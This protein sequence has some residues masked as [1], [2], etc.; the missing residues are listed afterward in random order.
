MRCFNLNFIG[1]CLT[2]EVDFYIPFNI[3][4]NYEFKALSTFLRIKQS[5]LTKVSLTRNLAMKQ[6]IISIGELNYIMNFKDDTVLLKK[7][8][9][10]IEKAHVNEQRN[11]FT[12]S[13]ILETE[14]RFSQEDESSL[15]KSFVDFKT[16]SPNSNSPTSPNTRKAEISS[17]SKGI[18]SRRI[19]LN[20]YL[21]NSLD[22]RSIEMLK[23]RSMSPTASPLRKKDKSIQDQKIYN[24]ATN[25][26]RKDFQLTN[27]VFYHVLKIFSD[28][29]LEKYERVL[30]IIRSKNEILGM[31][32]Y[33]QARS[34][35]IDIQQFAR[36]LKESVVLFYRIDQISTKEKTFNHDKMFGFI[37]SIIL[38]EPIYKVTFELLN[39]TLQAQ[40]RIYNNKISVLSHYKPEDVGVTAKVLP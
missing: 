3:I 26:L 21:R 38:T 25:L 29:Y 34:A 1:Y 30:V 18:T 27:N 15:T 32:I 33:N 10:Q 36:I 2:V 19:T 5:F 23:I 9:N 16:Q 35:V 7:L 37:T 14:N 8:D 13:V 40:E 39:F 12:C 6:V 4:Y 28:Y 24:L 22:D 31:E 17:P 20:G 11:Q